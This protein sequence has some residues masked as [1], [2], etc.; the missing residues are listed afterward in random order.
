MGEELLQTL[1][2]LEAG[3]GT[4][5]S[6]PLDGWAS[7]LRHVVNGSGRHENSSWIPGGDGQGHREEPG[8]RCGQPGTMGA[9][10]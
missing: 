2:W 7:P 1:K 10:E 3:P 5:W 4:P 9:G 6:A 8:T